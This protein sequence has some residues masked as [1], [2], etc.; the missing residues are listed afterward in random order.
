MFGMYKRLKASFEGVLTGKD[1]KWGGS[2]IRPEATGYGS[3]YY[4]QCMCRW[5]KDDLAG[6]RCVISGSGN[7][8]QYTCEKLLDLGAVPVTFSD[9]A[10]YVHKA[11]GWTREDLKKVMHL[12]NVARGRLSELTGTEGIEYF[13]GRKPWEQAC[14]AA[15]PSATQ[16][17]L[18][19]E[20]AKG[21]V[22]RGLKVVSEGANMP[23]TTDAIAVYH[24]SDVMY[25]PGKAANAGGVAVS[26]LEMAQDSQ[27][28]MWTREQVDARLQEIMQSIF[29]QCERYADKMG[30]KGNFQVGAN[31]AGFVKVA[32]SMFEQ[33][34]V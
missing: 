3:V 2:L 32:D 4:A 31:V 10:G 8:A 23:S 14:Y 17:E 12:K 24:S 25:G 29:D 19:A 26:G 7:V 13:A 27:R 33:G 9:S 5:A 6:K 20:D 11:S 15:F 16:N 30:C 1:P 22:S 18:D 21:M 28:L 34:C